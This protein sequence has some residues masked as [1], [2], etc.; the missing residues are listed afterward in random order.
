MVKVT[1][2]AG[3]QQEFDRKKMEK[4]YENIAQELLTKCPFEDFKQQMQNYLIEGISTND[5]VKMMI[6]TAVNLITIE[7]TDRQ[8]I[9]GRIATMDLYKHASRNRKISL[10]DIYTPEAY[11]AFFEEYVQEAKYDPDFFSHYSREDILEAGKHI[12][13]SRDME[14]GYTTV[15]MFKKRYLL[16]PNK[17]IKELPQEM[18]MSVALFLAIPEAK[19][20][21]LEVAFQM[22]EYIS[23][24][25]ISLPTPTLMNARTK[26][27][28]LSSCF[29]L[30]LDDDLRAIYHGVE[31]IAQISKFGGGV[32]VYLGNVR[33]KGSDIRGVK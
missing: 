5:L 6:K 8:L 33:C 23:S 2:H 32:G 15:S 4:S 18:Y 31:N 3:A 16:N 19:E 1:K 12:V 27:H 14:Y 7:N 24:Q 10:E 25:K 28:Q 22:Y 30:N 29:K 9:A 13:R 21:R 20:K 11:L 17:I 26:F